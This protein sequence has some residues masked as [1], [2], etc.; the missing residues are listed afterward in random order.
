MR[1]FLALLASST[2]LVACGGAHTPTDPATPAAGTPA[3]TTAPTTAAVLTNPPP[4]QIPGCLPKCWFGQLTR[5]GPL[6][7]D[8]KTKYFF[9]GQMTVTV[10]DGWFGYEDS[11]GELAIGP[12]DKGDFAKVEFWIDVYAV[13]DGN[14]TPDESIERSADAII[15]WFVD[16]SIIDVIKRQPATLGGLTAEAIEYERNDDGK[17]EVAD[18]PKEIQPCSAAFGYPEWDGSFGEGDHFHSVLVYTTATWGGETHSIYAMLWSLDPY[19]DQFADLAL[20]MIESARLPAGVQ[21]A[22]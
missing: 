4:T 8:Y 16:K 3:A 18:C 13:S 6:S 14:G 7:G 2:I 21:D 10:P 1:R 15:P 19:Y 5:P 20:E 12:A 11:T 9:G 22:P 17:N